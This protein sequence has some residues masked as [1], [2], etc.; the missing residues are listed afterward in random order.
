M[1]GA[2]LWRGKGSQS[3]SLGSGSDHAVASQGSRVLGEMSGAIWQR[4]WLTRPYGSLGSTSGLTLRAAEYQGPRCC[5][6]QQ[7][8]RLGS[9]RWL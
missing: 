2:Q 1:S 7:G 9:R 8:D 3:S 4:L 5:L 6:E